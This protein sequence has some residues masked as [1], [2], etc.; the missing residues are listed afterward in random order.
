VASKKTTK[1][2]KRRVTAKKRTLKDVPYK[3]LLEVKFAKE[4]SKR[5]D[6]QVT[7]ETVRLPYTL[8]RY[9]LPDFVCR[10]ADGKV[11]YIE[12]KG[13]FR[14]TDRVKL[15]AVREAHPEADVRLLFAAD[16]KISS[17]SLMRYSDWCKKNGFTYAVKEIPEEWF[18]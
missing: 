16:N 6:V 5:K 7:Y 17:K 15:K 18:I 10:G 12:V 4:L 3:S 14:G 9:Y 8:K 1:R 13:Y 2:R 11:F